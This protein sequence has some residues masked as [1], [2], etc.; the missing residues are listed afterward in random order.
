MVT[1]A[2]YS[3]PYLRFTLKEV[4]AFKS[5]LPLSR[6]SVRI[7]SSSTFFSSSC[8]EVTQQLYTHSCSMQA[9]TERERGRERERN[10]TFCACSSALSLFILCSSFSSSAVSSSSLHTKQQPWITLHTCTHTD[11]QIHTYTH[12]GHGQCYYICYK[13]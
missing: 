7:R 2:A 4:L 12:S 6:F 9:H 11:S 8:H 3:N 5:G 10:N 13:F 1:I